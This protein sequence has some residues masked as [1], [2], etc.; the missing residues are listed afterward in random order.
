MAEIQSFGGD[1]DESVRGKSIRSR[2]Q[3]GAPSL[4]LSIGNHLSSGLRW[5]S[6]E[7][8]AAAAR[9]CS[10][11]SVRE[12]EDASERGAC[13]RSGWP[14]PADRVRPGRLAPT[15]GLGPTGG[16]GLAGEREGFNQILKQKI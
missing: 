1:E 7:S 2:R 14:R 15:C 9:R 4:D 3:A 12:E 6:L 16:P 8:S 5:S 11:Q 13:D 10:R